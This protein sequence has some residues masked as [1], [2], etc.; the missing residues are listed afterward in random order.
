MKLEK[1]FEETETK[2]V[3]SIDGDYF[4]RISQSCVKDCVGIAEK[5]SIEFA[6]WCLNSN[7]YRKTAKELLEIYKKSLE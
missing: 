3:D 4:C 1:Q 6:E 5:F 7:T 2:V